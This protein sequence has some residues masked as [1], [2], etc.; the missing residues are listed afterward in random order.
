MRSLWQDLRRLELVSSSS[1]YPVSY[2]AHLGV[3]ELTYST[4]KR[5]YECKVPD[6]LRSFARRNT[7]LKHHRLT[8]PDLPPPNAEA[9]RPTVPLPL[10]TTQRLAPGPVL[11]PGPPDSE[12]RPQ[13]WTKTSS[14]ITNS[15]TAPHA[16]AVSSPSGSTAVSQQDGTDLD[17]GEKESESYDPTF[18]EGQDDKRTFAFGT[19][20]RGGRTGTGRGRGRGGGRGS[21]GGIRGRVGSRG[22]G[23]TATRIRDI[24]PHLNSIG[25]RGQVQSQG[26]TTDSLVL[27]T[28][29]SPAETEQEAS[30]STP[31]SSTYTELH[32]IGSTGSQSI[33]S[34][35][36]DSSISVNHGLGLR[37]GVESQSQSHSNLDSIV[38]Q[39]AFHSSVHSHHG[40]ANEY[41]LGSYTSAPLSA[42]SESGASDFN[43]RSQNSVMNSL[44]GLRDQV[45]AVHSGN[46]DARSDV[47]NSTSG[48]NV[49]TQLFVPN[50]FTDYSH[51]SSHRSLDDASFGT[52]Q[53][54]QINS[55]SLRATSNP[56]FTRPTVNTS[57][58]DGGLGGGFSMGQVSL[59]DG[60][61]QPPIYT[62]HDRSVSAPMTRDHS[63]SLSPELV[64][65]HAVPD[66][67][68][69]APTGPAVH[70]PYSAVDGYY[71]PL[72]HAPPR[73]NEPTQ[74]GR[75]HSAPPHMQ[76]F[77]SLPSVPTQS[78]IW[79][80][81]PLSAASSTFTQLSSPIQDMGQI[82]AKW[83]NM[84]SQDQIQDQSAPSSTPNQQVNQVP[85]PTWSQPIHYPNPPHPQIVA[86]NPFST[87]LT[88][89]SLS[90]P[91]LNGNS[92]MYAQSPY[93]LSQNQQQYHHQ[94][95]HPLHLQQP[96]PPMRVQHHYNG[97]SHSQYP[98]H[99]QQPPQH[100]Q[101]HQHH[102]QPLP[103]QQYLPTPTPIT[104]N[105]NFT[106]Y[107]MVSQPTSA[108]ASPVTFSGYHTAS[109][110]SPVDPNPR[111][112]SDEY[113]QHNVLLTTPPRYTQE[114]NTVGLGISNVHFDDHS[115][116]YIVDSDR[117][118]D[119]ALS[120]DV[121]QE[122]QNT[123]SQSQ[124]TEMVETYIEGEPELD[125]DGDEFIFEDESD[126][127]FIPGKKQKRKTKP[128]RKSKGGQGH[129]RSS[130]GNESGN[131][132]GIKM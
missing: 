79:A 42:I 85:T 47:N 100:L 102:S 57:N 59:P 116:R 110:N 103:Q 33:F 127:E 86:R 30:I 105:Y 90:T 132:S 56:E 20:S 121:K 52:H 114:V 50:A 104:P 19:R 49:N 8:H 82:E 41:G 88:S 11:Q 126:E 91:S 24:P 28:N 98:T 128:G 76:R 27:R 83:V 23:A 73:L 4:G 107:R 125:S 78:S 13:Y 123:Q 35:D 2:S 45:N 36:F 112:V 43:I 51:Q 130:S 18:V 65:I 29:V 111:S 113:R 6:C 66:F 15:I 21:R 64:D 69:Q 131:E 58:L 115:H 26:E 25:S 22:G 84:D 38:K 101:A 54:R 108:L 1:T 119:P 7:F 74:D 17:D 39:Q 97:I 95:Q 96:A 80:T 117:L 109:H 5:P 37:I 44:N 93:M 89:Y 16:Y 87:P 63:H 55:H 12:G 129:K 106:N 60:S 46:I 120:L 81:A 92:P 3:S 68:I 94:Q 71:N 124:L 10:Y 48:L 31:L 67:S 77:N 32:E 99:P 75:L 53:S 14:Q 62:S 70:V 61:L 40:H 122:R 72:T 34:P 118:L 9:S